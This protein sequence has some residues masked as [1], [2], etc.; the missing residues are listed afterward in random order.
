M[1]TLVRRQA[2]KTNIA[3]TTAD[4]DAYLISEVPQMCQMASAIAGYPLVSILGNLEVQ[5]IRS[6]HTQ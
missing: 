3:L 4:P 2:E 1:L 5:H 6:G